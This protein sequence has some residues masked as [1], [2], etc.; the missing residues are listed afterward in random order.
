M[1]H[2]GIGARKE[3]K[4]RGSK[5]QVAKAGSSS[6]NGILCR[7]RFACVFSFLY[8]AHMVLYVVV[9]YHGMGFSRCDNVFSLALPF[10]HRLD[11]MGSHTSVELDYRMDSK[12]SGVDI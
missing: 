3:K 8:L 4:A 9:F 5:D 10:P 12:L 2:F 1:E 6:Y 7:Y 11:E